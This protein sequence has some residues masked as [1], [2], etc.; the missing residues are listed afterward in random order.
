M[1]ESECPLFF[2]TGRR[3]ST[4][5]KHPIGY[6]VGSSFSASL[7]VLAAAAEM[8][9]DSVVVVVIAV[10]VAVSEGLC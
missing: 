2:A 9:A 10:V 7:V 3:A 8:I 6:S 1:G 5:R 4:T